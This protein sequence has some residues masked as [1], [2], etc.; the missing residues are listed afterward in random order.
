MPDTSLTAGPGGTLSAPGG[1]T[2]PGPPGHAGE[3]ALPG[4]DRAGLPAVTPL[5]FGIVQSLKADLEQELGRDAVLTDDAARLSASTDW[6][7]MS[8]VLQPMLP[9]GVA[10]VVVKPMDAAG[11]A[12]AVAMA[13]TA[14]APISTPVAQVFLRI[15]A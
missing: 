15:V 13:A 8:P 3:R 14:V 12:A 6:A 11:I 5:P 10:D 9:G 4:F 7:H 2:P 1:T